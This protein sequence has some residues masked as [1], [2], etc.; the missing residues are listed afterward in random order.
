MIGGMSHPPPTLAEESATPD[1][2]LPS[3]NIS[4][5]AVASLEPDKSKRHGTKSATAFRN[6]VPEIA[7]QFQPYFASIDEQA[8]LTVL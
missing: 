3:T 8:L 6:G 1:L 5:D 7:T 2:K 4:L